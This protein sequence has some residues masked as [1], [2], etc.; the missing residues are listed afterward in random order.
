MI[1]VLLILALL[2]G[3]LEA[4]KK[5]F[6]LELPNKKFIKLNVFERA[7]YKKAYN[8]VKKGNY[9][10]AVDEFEKFK[11]QHPDNS[12]MAYVLFMKA[13]CLHQAKQR[14]KAIKTYNEVLD[15]FGDDV[16][17]AGAALYFMAQA[18]F[19]NGDIK[20]GLK[21]LKEMAEDKDYQKH[22]LAAG[23]FRH[24][25]DNLL[26][27]KKP[28]E[29]I[30][31][32]KLIA[33][34]FNKDNK[35][36]TQ[37]AMTELCHYYI[38]KKQFSSYES[39]IKEI[40]EK[41]KPYQ[42]A[43]NLMSQMGSVLKFRDDSKWIKYTEFKSSGKSALTKEFLVYFRGKK[44]SFGKSQWTYHSSL[45][46]FLGQYHKA[47]FP[48]ELKETEAFIKTIKDKKRVDA[49]YGSL[50]HTLLRRNASENFDEAIR[51]T[52]MVKDVDSQ[53]RHYSSIVDSMIRHR[54]LDSAKVLLGRLKDQKTAMWKKVSIFST[55]KKYDD[56]VKTMDAIAKQF[57]KEELNVKRRKAGL[58]HHIGKYPE[59]IKLYR[60]IGTPPNSLWSIADCYVKLKNI[61]QAITT[62]TELE[63]AFPKSA[64]DAALKKTR[65]YQSIKD[66]KKTI[67]Q[68][69]RILKVYPKSKASSQAHQILEDYGIKTGGGV[70][71][72]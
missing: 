42:T 12:Q 43:L 14:N 65:I 20:S 27:N 40:N 6:D 67:A 4:R 30:K 1:R 9:K 38:L 5:V 8:L 7:Q 2:P 36:E 24:L 32:L 69:R 15:F 19:D 11:H 64:P 18:H 34:N 25:A 22:A 55:Q 10:A 44:S 28:A 49:C 53:Q 72:E 68:A 45:L 17:Y 37:I 51:Y 47:E 13:Y 66:K 21:T 60:E 46:D 56:V 57:P 59:A 71:E 61:K 26:K 29:A 35:K 54:K 58:Y 23:A 52:S 70:I 50:I 33:V 48:K 41:Q 63:N 39:F 16:L 62:L 3:W 31:Y